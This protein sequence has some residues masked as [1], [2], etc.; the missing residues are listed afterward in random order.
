MFVGATEHHR[1]SV[2]THGEEHA[3]SL[4]RTTNDGALDTKCGYKAMTF[5]MCKSS[6]RAKDIIS[7]CVSMYYARVM[8]DTL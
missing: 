4:Y 5:D 8:S 6:V 7:V 1:A 3:L 2:Q